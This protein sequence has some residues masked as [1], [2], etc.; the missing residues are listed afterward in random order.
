ME[1]VLKGEAWDSFIAE[2]KADEDYYSYSR[3]LILEM[4]ERHLEIAKRR[5]NEANRC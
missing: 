2:I 3:D 4:L 5:L 1:S